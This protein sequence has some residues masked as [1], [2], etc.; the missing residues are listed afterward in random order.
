MKKL[1]A[2]LLAVSMVF[3]LAACGSKT[4]N[5]QPDNSSSLSDKLDNQE[6]QDQLGNEDNI[7]NTYIKDEISIADKTATSLSPWGTNC[8]SPGVYEVYEMLYECDPNGDMYPLLA[9]GTY[10]GTYMAGCDHEEGTGVYT[11]KIYDCIYDHNGNHVTAEDVA[12][13][14]MYQYENETTSGWQ[15]LV[16]VEAAD[17]TTVVF[18]FAKEQNA[19]GQ[20]LNIFARCFIVDEETHKGSQSALA[21]EMIGTG[22]YKMKNYTSGSVLTIERNED[23][24]QLKAGMTPRQEQQAN[25]Q[26]INYKFIDEAAQKLVALKT[27]EIDFV[28]EMEAAS[29]VDFAD[30]GEFADQYNL[31]QYPAKFVYY[32]N[33]NCDSTSICNDINMRLAIFNAI[34]Q[35]G[36]ITALGGVET[37]IYGYVS[38]YSAFY[39]ADWVDYAALDNYN[40]RTGVD[41]DVVNDYLTKAGYNGETITLVTAGTTTASEVIAAQLNAAGIKCELKA[42]DQSSY[43]STTADPG[44]WD[45]DFGMMAGSEMATVWLHGFSY[46]NM[47]GT[48][49]SNFVVNQEWE[50]LLNEIQ[51]EAG[52]T[53]ENMQ[54]WWNIAVENAY[55]M[56]LYNGVMFD[57]VP[58]DMT[59]VCLGDKQTPLPGACTYAAPEA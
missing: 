21:T 38:Y 27:G 23:Y 55:T 43:R 49:T 1:L 58:E 31:Y 33:P 3:A 48:K 12:Y 29:T 24:W 45:L 19:V 37:R 7:D 57:V 39:D 30:G 6:A 10:E 59:Y 56:G 34:D 15:D 4:G 28:H 5:E 46:A 51:T 14:Y 8:G 17:E 11:V 41:M 40:T 36:L 54:K 53:A 32:L 18:T 22:P 35:D 16:S 25:V 50:D 52:H 44:A 20:I 13:S 42:L 26:I 47:D 9:D 2:L